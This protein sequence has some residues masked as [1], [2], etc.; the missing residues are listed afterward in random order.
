M[1]FYEKYFA[2]LGEIQIRRDVIESTSKLLAVSGK[3]ESLHAVIEEQQR[4]LVED[5]KGLEKIQKSM[6][7]LKEGA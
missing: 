2:L 4:M 6:K 3:L 5:G 7:D 1:Q